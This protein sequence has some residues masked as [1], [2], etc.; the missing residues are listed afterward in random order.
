MSLF[1]FSLLYCALAALCMAMERHYKQVWGDKPAAS[2]RHTLKATGWI[3]LG[4]SFWISYQTW[5]RGIGSLAWFGI[6]TIAAF[7]FILMLTYRP[8]V[9]LYAAP[10]LPI[11]TGA[12]AAI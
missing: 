8:R 2:R 9:A 10:I 12:V 7:T 11:I 1:V 4:V 5:E 6:L 3:L